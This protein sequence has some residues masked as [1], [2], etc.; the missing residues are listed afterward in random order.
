MRN[1]FPRLQQTVLIKTEIFLRSGTKIDNSFLDSQFFIEGLKMD[2]K[3]RTTN[4]GK[5]LLFVNENLP[6]D[7]INSCKFKDN[8]KRI[9][10]EFSASN[11]K[12]LF[13]VIINLPCKMIKI[14]PVFRIIRCS[15]PR[16]RLGCLI[17]I[18]Q[19]QAHSEKL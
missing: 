16:L 19:Q 8:Y 17:T 13:W 15:S 4:G 5:L 12:W 2:H 3:D 10:F 9:L 6:C 7:I 18:N 1:K 11:N 14:L